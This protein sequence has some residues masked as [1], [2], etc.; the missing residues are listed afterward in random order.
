[1]VRPAAQYNMLSFQSFDVHICF[2]S[3]FDV[4]MLISDV[5]IYYSSMLQMNGK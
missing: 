5:C 3:E 4:Q 1:M 2:L